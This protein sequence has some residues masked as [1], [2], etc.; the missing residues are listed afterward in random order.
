MNKG[1]SWWCT[2]TSSIDALSNGCHFGK[3][4]QTDNINQINDIFD[5]PLTMCIPFI[6]WVNIFDGENLFSSRRIT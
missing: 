6:H 4:N 1:R 5:G 3:K 2:I